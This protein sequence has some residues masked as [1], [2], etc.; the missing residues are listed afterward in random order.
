MTAKTNEQVRAL[1]DRLEEVHVTHGATG[2]AGNAVFNREQKGRYV[3]AVDQPARHNALHA[4]MP[5]LAA[6]D[7][8]TA[9]VIRPL[10]E[11]LSLL[12]ELCLDGA[13]FLVDLL[14]ARGKRRR[15][16]GVTG[17]KQ[18]ERQG[19]VGHAS[20]GVQAR[21]ERERKPIGGD[22]REVRSGHRRERDVTGPCR[23]AHVGNTVCHQRAVL[24]RKK[25]H[26]AHR[27][28]GGDLGKRT[29]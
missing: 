13:A 3:V 14:K 10:D 9:A 7:D 24:G 28:E 11:L 17:H 20:G 5:P 15:F 29:P 8:A 18:V 2:A 4:L 26:V 16:I 12:G 6:H 23:G 27:S 19:G 21:N 22:G 1:L 25:H